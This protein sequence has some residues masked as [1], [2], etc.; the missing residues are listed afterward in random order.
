MGS[1][2]A[3]AFPQIGGPVGACTGSVLLDACRAKEGGPLCDRRARAYVCARARARTREGTPRLP[4]THLHTRCPGTTRR[5]ALRNTGERGEK[6]R[7]H[8][9]TRDQHEDDSRD[10]SRGRAARASILAPEVKIIAIES[11][12]DA[13]T[14]GHGGHG[15]D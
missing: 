14:R 6:R 13:A 15:L 2:R 11:T 5:T 1:S 8:A 4:R 9:T 7:A 12:E 3:G 10:P